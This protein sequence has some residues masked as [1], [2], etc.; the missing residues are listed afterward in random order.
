MNWGNCAPKNSKALG[1][2]ALATKPRENNERAPANF[3]SSMSEDLA[4]VKPLELN[5]LSG[6]DHSLGQQLGVA[7]RSTAPPDVHWC[8]T[9]TAERTSES[10]RGMLRW[11]LPIQVSGACY[12]SRAAAYGFY[13]STAELPFKLVGSCVRGKPEVPHSVRQAARKTHPD[14][15]I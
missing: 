9:S 2:L 8:S 5:W 10:P 11:R 13:Q 3:R 7:R 4:P 15:A 14:P 6:R 12:G 1:L